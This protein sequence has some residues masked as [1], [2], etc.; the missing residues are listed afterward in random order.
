MVSSLDIIYL[1]HSNCSKVVIKVLKK[2]EGNFPLLI[3]TFIL[4]Y[5][6]KKCKMCSLEEIGKLVYPSTKE[7]LLSQ[8]DDFENLCKYV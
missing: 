8:L 4:G 2:A 7:I 1:K 3:F 5:N 6:I